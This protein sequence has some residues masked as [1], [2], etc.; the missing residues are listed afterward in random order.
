M[1]ARFKMR[2]K[3]LHRQNDFAWMCGQELVLGTPFRG[4]PNAKI[5]FRRG[6]FLVANFELSKSLSIRKET[7]NEI[8]K[9]KF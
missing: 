2:P 3:S 4:G 5:K 9:P 7:R 6:F 8:G 1:P